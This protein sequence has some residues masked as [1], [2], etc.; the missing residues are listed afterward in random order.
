L[1]EGDT[2][3]GAFLAF[4]TSLREID[5][6]LDLNKQELTLFNVEGY[7]E[8]HQILDALRPLPVRKILLIDSDKEDNFYNSLLPKVDLLIR[9]PETPAGDD[10]E[11]MIAWQSSREILEQAIELQM[12]NQ[13]LAKQL[14]RV[15]KRRVWD[16]Q[17]SGRG[18]AN[19]LQQ[20]LELDQ[21]PLYFSAA[22]PILADWE[23]ANPREKGLL[24]GLYAEIFRE[25]KGCRPAFEWASLYSGN[26][27]PAAV[28][29]LFE[30]IHGLLTGRI[31]TGALHV[32]T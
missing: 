27:L 13:K 31:S 24:R 15:F 8:I 1:V 21:N 26:Q 14:P 16:I 18:N 28:V 9:T 5:Q 7:T 19:F 12:R 20:L 2:E 25:F 10:F 6:G 11:G 22:F 32:L 3:E 30:M 29:E 17:Q 4:N 23:N